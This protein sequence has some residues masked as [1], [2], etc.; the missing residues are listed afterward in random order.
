MYA[1]SMFL[2][3]ATR[4]AIRW[5][6]LLARRP[7]QRVVRRT[8]LAVAHSRVARCATLCLESLANGVETR[9]VSS[10]TEPSATDAV[11]H[12]RPIGVILQLEAAPSDAVADVADAS[13]PCF[14]TNE[15]RQ[16]AGDNDT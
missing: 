10:R 9:L 8:N 5:P 11:R 3:V 14:A 13:G 7:L 15:G 2:G 4:E 12:V 1:R 16:A 6:S